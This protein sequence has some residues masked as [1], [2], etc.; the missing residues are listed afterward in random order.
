MSFSVQFALE[1]EEVWRAVL[2]W[3]KY[4]AGVPLEK[5]PGV[6]NE[7]EK[8]LVCQVSFPWTFFNVTIKII[9]INIKWFKKQISSDF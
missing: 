5:S 6:W 1:E 3:A 7:H 9:F 2:E 4:H 8:S